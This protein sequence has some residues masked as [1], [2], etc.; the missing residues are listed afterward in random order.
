MRALL[1]KLLDWYGKGARALP[2][3]QGPADPYRIWISEVMSQQSTM[4]TV[5]PYFERWVEAYPGL[6]ELAASSEA[7]LMQLW[8]GLGYY[9]RARNLLKS[10]QIL[11]A[12]IKAGGDWPRLQAEW[13]ELPGVGPYTAAAV[14][15]IALNEAV[16]PIDGN[17]IRV[18]ARFWGLSDPLNRSTD[19]SRIEAEIEKLAE[20]AP[21]KSHSRL[22]QAL[23]ELGSQIC[24]PGDKALC[25]LCPLKTGCLAYQREQVAQIPRPKARPTTQNVHQVALFYRN[26]ENAVLLRQIPAGQRLQDQWELPHFESSEAEIEAL[27]RHFPLPPKPVSHAITR[28]RYQVYALDAGLWPERKAPPGHQ[29]WRP[30]EAWSGTITTLTRKL[31]LKEEGT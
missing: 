25:E 24:R 28:Y 12:R 4:V 5:V 15:A 20:Q 3:R 1:P 13:L 9:S 17:V 19:K 16:L 23:M 8:A 27:R 6:H 21:P 31:L 10:A 14:R 30:G 18:A 29:F 7:Q 22:A 26:R 2:W 11:S